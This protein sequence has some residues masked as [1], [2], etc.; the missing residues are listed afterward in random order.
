VLVTGPLAP[1]AE[2]YRRELRE[3]GYTER[4]AVNE[5]RQ[6]ARFSRWLQA[7][8]L[9]VW[10][11][12]AG[13]VEEFLGW[14]RAVGCHR[15]QW[16]RP[17]LVCL[18]D[19]LREL[20]MLAAGEP[21]RA[22]S[23]AEVLLAGFVRYLEAERGLAAGTVRGYVS[24]ARRFLGGLPAATGLA[25]VRAKDVTEAVL[26][27]SAAVSVSATQFFVAGLRSFLRFCF[28]EGQVPVDLSQA[29]LPVTGRRRSPLP[30]GITK[31]DARALLDGCDRRSALGRRDYAMLVTL[32]RLGLRAG[33]VARL[34][35]DDIDWRA[36]ELVVRGK[37]AR[38]DR[39]PLPAEVGQAVAC[40]LRRGRPASGR[41]EV[42]LQARAP[43]GPIAAGTV[44]STVRRAC[45][46]AGVAEVGAHRL[47]HTVACEMVAA[48]V[49][50]AEIA[51][52]LRHHS[53][54]TTA[55]YGRV[56]LDRLRAL[57][58]PWPGSVQR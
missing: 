20:G 5:L 40:Y 30:R 4:S 25:G 37:S 58:A 49:P 43:F 31:A 36:G 51:Q 34:R 8:R 54:Q 9:S 19:V 52:V 28:I 57:A 13:R 10:E 45:R 35:L 29:A 42:F 12:S 55:L 18:L 6:V 39:L 56:D 33:E 1:F 53:L 16:S 47:R 3:R 46:R 38:E 15:S 23:P 50:L 7:G 27:E 17:G 21:V 26:R 44:S 48:G 2:D 14:Q 11:L 32:L 22:A 24:H 41:R